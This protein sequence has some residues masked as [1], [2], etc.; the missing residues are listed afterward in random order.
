VSGSFVPADPAMGLQTG[1]LLQ[2]H[3]GHPMSYFAR[4]LADGTLIA[5]DHG[6]HRQNLERGDAFA[7][8]RYY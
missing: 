1:A 3:E 5:S 7:S 8:Q 6:P 4:I 2:G